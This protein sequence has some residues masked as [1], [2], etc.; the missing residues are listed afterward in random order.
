MFVK[1]QA[2]EFDLFNYCNW[3]SIQQQDRIWVYSVMFRE[4]HTD[5]F[6]LRKF[7][8]MLKFIECLLKMAFNYVHISGAVTNEKIINIERTLHAHACSGKEEP[9]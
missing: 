6:G 5:C 2:Q 3:S 4:V 8:S 1:N 7:E 9:P